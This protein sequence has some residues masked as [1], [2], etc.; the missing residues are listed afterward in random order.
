[1]GRFEKFQQISNSSPPRN[2]HPTSKSMPDH[3]IATNFPRIIC[4]VRFLITKHVQ[5]HF[6]TCLN[7]YRCLQGAI[8]AFKP[9]QKWL[10]FISN[11]PIQPN[12]TP[13]FTPFFPYSPLRK[14]IFGNELLNPLMVTNFD[15][16]NALLVPNNILEAW[17]HFIFVFQQIFGHIT[18]RQVGFK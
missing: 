16:K 9:P 12:R 11:D 14:M 6:Q 7:T 15:Q 13:K 4:C 8:R 18:R 2:F 17:R 3:K 1:M 10:E 5:G